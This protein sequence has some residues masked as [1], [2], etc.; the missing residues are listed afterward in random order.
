MSLPDRIREPLNA[1]HARLLVRRPGLLERLVAVSLSTALAESLRPEELFALSRRVLVEGAKNRLANQDLVRGSRCQ[2]VENAAPLR[3]LH[4]QGRGAVV[5]SLH[6]GPFHHALTEAAAIHPEVVVFAAEHLRDHFQRSWDRI[7]RDRSFALDVIPSGGRAGLLRAVKALRGG[8]F[9]VIFVDSTNRAGGRA[10]TP[11]RDVEL[12]FLTLPFRMSVG[13]AFL[14]ARAGVP[15]VC[16]RARREGWR[17]TIQFSDPL[18]VPDTDPETLAAAVRQM[19]QWLETGVREKPEAWDGWVQHLLYWARSGEPPRVTRDAWDQRTRELETQIQAGS[20]LRLR[21]EPAHVAW[22]GE[23]AERLVF[24]GP[25]RRLIKA[26]PGIV[27]LLG[28][29]ERGVTL[30]ELARRASVPRSELARELARL[31]LAGL[32]RIDP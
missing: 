12:E 24:H 27:A 14:A 30:T 6:L 31:E 9:G 15:L 20:H 8:A 17:R 4:A 32:A 19:Y 13:P 28:A 21:V 10:G 1:L 25:K 3:A 23:G 22:L 5:A 16:A 29:G 11:E 2:V 7:A 18:E 26:T